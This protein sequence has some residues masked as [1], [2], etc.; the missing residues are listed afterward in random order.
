MAA[1][2]TPYVSGLMRVEPGFI[3]Y[4]GHMN[5]AYYQVLFDRHVDGVFN[6]AGI[7]QE[8]LGQRQ[9]SFFALETHI[10]YR[11]ELKL[12]DPVRA[13]LRLIAHDGK[14]LHFAMEMHHAEAGFL[15][16]ATDH[17]SI[18][19][20]MR[21]RKSAP[22]AADVSATLDAM[23]AAHS[24]LPAWEFIGRRVEIKRG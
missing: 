11:R 17:L 6:Q 10:V 13:K 1:I 4:N 16:A 18:H 24:A 14:R 2:E 23:L 12:G 19:I 3:D 5:L 7:G 20:D 21:T 9:C 15:A 22:Y 8:Y